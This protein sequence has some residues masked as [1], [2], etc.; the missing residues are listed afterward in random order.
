MTELGKRGGTH[1]RKTLPLQEN[2]FR[3]RS[4]GKSTLLAAAAAMSNT[5]G[6]HYTYFI[7]YSERSC[8]L[9]KE[10]C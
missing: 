5:D 9:I 3:S 10:E 8:H 6:P 2:V 7:S 4:I 1:S